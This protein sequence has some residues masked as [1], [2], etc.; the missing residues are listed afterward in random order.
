MSIINGLP[1]QFSHINCV[2]SIIGVI[3]SHAIMLL[4]TENNKI[5]WNK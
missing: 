2:L 3:F 4:E 1:G 5:A